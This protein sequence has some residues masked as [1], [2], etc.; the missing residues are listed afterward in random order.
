M[1]SLLFIFNPATKT[2]FWAPGVLRELHLK[3]P[4]AAVILTIKAV[5]ETNLPSKANCDL[6]TTLKFSP[7][8]S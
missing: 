1:Y 5:V 6:E 8:F 2:E 3:S 7:N 4:V